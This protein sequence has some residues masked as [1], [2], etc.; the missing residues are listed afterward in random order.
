MIL[1]LILIRLLAWHSK[2]KKHKA[3]KKKISEELIPIVW[4]P[5]RCWNFRILEDKKKETGL[6]FT[7]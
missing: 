3:L 2:F 7:E 4:H 6:K 5:K 1:I